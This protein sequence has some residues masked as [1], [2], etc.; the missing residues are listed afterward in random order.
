MLSRLGDAIPLDRVE[1][2]TD[3]DELIALQ[4]EA[5]DVFVS[6]AV[7]DYMVALVRATREHAGLAMGASPRATRGLY[8]AAKVWA[9]MEGR[10]YVLP[11]DVQHLL[12]PVL[13][14]RLVLTGEARFAGNTAAGILREICERVDVPQPLGAAHGE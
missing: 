14:H 2:V 5:A 12:L 3:A 7:Q 1:T 9:A 10:D 6:E 11:D 8:R 4:K 13:A